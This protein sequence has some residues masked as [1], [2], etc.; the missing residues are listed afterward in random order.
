MV[1]SSQIPKVSTYSCYSSTAY[2]IGPATEALNR[3]ANLPSSTEKGFGAES[4]VDRCLV[5]PRSAAY[6][7]AW[8]TSRVKTRPSEIYKNHFRYDTVVT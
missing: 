1:L 5:V 6:R 2:I 4:Y 7:F 8:T 3:V